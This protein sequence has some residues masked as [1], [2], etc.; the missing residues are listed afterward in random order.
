VLE[1][2]F[3]H[4][5]EP[6]AVTPVAVRVE[7]DEG[8][9]LR[10]RRTVE[11]ARLLLALD[12][13]RALLE[14]PPGGLRVRLAGMPSPHALRG[15]DGVGL[16]MAIQIDVRLQARLEGGADRARLVRVGGLPLGASAE[17]EHGDT[18]VLE[19]SGVLDPESLLGEAL[20]LFPLAEGLSLSPVFPRVDW[21]VSGDGTEVVLDLSDLPGPLAL[22]WARVGWRGLDGMPPEAPS[23]VTLRR[24]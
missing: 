10:V 2:R 21:I 7:T 19:F 4:E 24:R 13:D 18:L 15:V 23:V 22:H 11:G 16:E 9:A 3:D 20:P 12:V 5:L 8:R 14:Q 1:L 6:L 17:W